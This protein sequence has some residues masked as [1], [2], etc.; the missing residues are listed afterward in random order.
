MEI[1]R[2]EMI[3]IIDLENRTLNR[4]IDELGPDA[5][6]ELRPGETPATTSIMCASDVR[7]YASC[8]EQET[9]FIIGYRK[10]F[11]YLN[12]PDFKSIEIW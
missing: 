7:L 6:A 8:N 3:R 2:K 9:S 1:M 5:I 12:R 10:I 11:T 4:I